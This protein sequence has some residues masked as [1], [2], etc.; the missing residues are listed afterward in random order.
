[1]FDVSPPAAG[2]SSCLFSHACSSSSSS[3]TRLETSMPCNKFELPVCIESHRICS[4]SASRAV[5]AAEQLSAQHACMILCL[6]VICQEHVLL[7]QPA[8][9]H[10][11][12][13]LHQKLIIFIHR[14][15]GTLP[16]SPI[17]CCHPLFVWT[18][19]T[20]E[21]YAWHWNVQN[22]KQLVPS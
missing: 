12:C 15:T 1:M 10:V 13:C 5:S 20:C 7:A 19:M 8:G 2:D 16:V 4:R 21:L 11:A 3:T 17:L 9:M 22:S 14:S 6:P 18:S